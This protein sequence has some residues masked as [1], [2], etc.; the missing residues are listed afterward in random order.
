[1]LR[2][3]CVLGHGAMT[4]SW[5][6]LPHTRQSASRPR[7]R[8][9]RRSRAKASLPVASCRLLHS[10]G[11]AA[12]L[13]LS[14]LYVPAELEFS[15]HLSTYLSVA[16]S[17]RGSGDVP[18][19]HARLATRFITLHVLTET[20]SAPDPL[21]LYFSSSVAAPSTFALARLMLL[22]LPMF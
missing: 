9:R 4:N 19:A 17:R 14:T 15:G 7:P 20:S 8:K 16:L 18:A 11:I 21:P 12:A 13:H 2:S 10:H 3:A 6:P 5:R 1:M 22:E